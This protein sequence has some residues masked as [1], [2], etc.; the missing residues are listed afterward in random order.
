[1]NINITINKKHLYMFFSVIALLGIAIFVRA[2][3]LNTNVPWH[4]LQQVST[5]PSSG[6]SVDDGGDGLID[7]SNFAQIASSATNALGIKNK[8]IYWDSTDPNKLCYD[9]SGSSCTNVQTPV[10]TVY[11]GTLITTT[12]GG[13]F[14]CESACGRSCKLTPACIG[15]SLC[16]SNPSVF[17]TYG[18]GTP[19][20]LGSDR[21]DCTCTRPSTPAQTYVTGTQV[22]STRKCVTFTDG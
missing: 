14:G 16:S 19:Q 22:A 9:F 2:A 6:L 17:F 3:S 8:P 7:Y 12:D 15:N 18:D 11:S 21:C 10:C 5:T 20:G 13:P 4:P 1:M